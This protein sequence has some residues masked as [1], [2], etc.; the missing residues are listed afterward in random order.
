[1]ASFRVTDDDMIYCVKGGNW[2]S[3]AENCQSDSV[4]R[5][6][7]LPKNRNYSLVGFRPICSL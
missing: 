5:Y 4:I 2:F 3:D 7:M 1:M 6:L